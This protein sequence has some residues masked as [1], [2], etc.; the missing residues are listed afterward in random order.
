MLVGLVH[1]RV[2]IVQ[3]APPQEQYRVLSQ[4]GLGGDQG[5]ANRK[6]DY[7]PVIWSVEN[8]HGSSIDTKNAL[9]SAAFFGAAKHWSPTDSLRKH[10]K[11]RCWRCADMSMTCRSNPKWVRTTP[12]HCTLAD[13]VC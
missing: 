4:R 13:N 2:V 10:K 9:A 1:D 7:N 3:C 5:F 12:I 6:F 8:V 11:V